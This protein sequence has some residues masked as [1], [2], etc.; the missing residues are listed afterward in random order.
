L[1][2]ARLSSTRAAWASVD[3]APISTMSAPCAASTF[4]AL[5][6]RF[7]RQADAF[8]IPR[9]GGEIDDAHDGG[10][11]VEIEFFAAD[12]KFLHARGRGGAVFF[13]KFGKMF[14]L[15]F[16]PCLVLNCVCRIGEQAKARTPTEMARPARFERTTACLEGRCSIQLSYGRGQTD[17]NGVCV[18]AQARSRGGFSLVE[19]FSGF[20]QADLV[21]TT[22]LLVLLLA[23]ILLAGCGKTETAAAPPSDDDSLPTQAQPKLPTMK[24]YLGAETLDTELALT[25]REEMTGMMFRTNIQDSDSMLFVLPQPE[26]ASFWMK[27]C[28]ES[29]SAAYISPDGVIQEIH[30]LEKND[31]NAVLAAGRQH[32]VCFGNQRR[33]VRAA[34]RQHRR[35]HPHRKRFAG[36]YIFAK[37]IFDAP[38]RRTKLGEDGNLMQADGNSFPVFILDGRL[39][40]L[41]FECFHCVKVKI[42]PNEPTQQHCAL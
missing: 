22:N 36:G 12:G 24:I 20:R 33:L 41:A 40:Q 25:E 42:W 8:A 13:Q 3:S 10:L 14:K 15:E 34:Q 1:I 29:I 27:N 26:R 30:H 32:P 21:K 6:R 31:T 28:P 18:A 39:G 19:N 7:R 9:I 4:P 5:D 16:K 35:R 17:I 11:R 37:M 38:T 23:A 2:F